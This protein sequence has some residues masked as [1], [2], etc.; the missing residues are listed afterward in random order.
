MAL[1]AGN[2]VD[3][4]YTL[5]DHNN[6]KRTMTIQFDGTDP[7]ANIVATAH[8]TAPPLVEALTLCKIGRLNITIGYKDT[9]FALTDIPVEA[10]VEG[11]G[12]FVM[13]TE[14]DRISKVE[15]PGFTGAKVLFGSNLVDS[16]DSDV[17]AWVDF[18]TTAAASG[19]ARPSD[20]LGGNL[21]SLA[22]APKLIH[23]KN[24]E[25]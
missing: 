19:F 4:T 8:T 20:N 25:G 9:S 21:T 14:D 22:S 3:A 16:T 11:K 6:N 13:N 24:S 5:I 12:V 7:I 2:T 1:S 17:I 10:S 18:L 23:R 15:V